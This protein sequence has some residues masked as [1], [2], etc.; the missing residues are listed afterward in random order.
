MKRLVT[1]VENEAIFLETVNRM[2][3]SVMVVEK[4]VIYHVTALKL[5]KMKGNAIIVELAGTLVRSAQNLEVMQMQMKQYAT[6]A[7][8]RA[9]L[10]EIAAL[11]VGTSATPVAKLGI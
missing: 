8:R 2:I 6:N 3:E 4:L 9:T 1:F 5:T 10:L 11:L 7:T